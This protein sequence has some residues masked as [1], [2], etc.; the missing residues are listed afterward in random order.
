VH[1]SGSDLQHEEHV[2]PLERHCGSPRGRS[3][4]AASSTPGRAGT[5]ARSCRCPRIG[6]GGIPHRCRMR[7]IVEAPTRWPSL[8]N[9][10]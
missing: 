10:P 1:G 2:D 7:R 5:V 4:R 3:R 6:A 8:S 9:S